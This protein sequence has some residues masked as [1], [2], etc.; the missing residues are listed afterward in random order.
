MMMR[1]F[2]RSKADYTED[3]K[4]KKRSKSYLQGSKQ[5]AT[6]D[7]ADDEHYVAPRTTTSSRRLITAYGVV[8]GVNDCVFHVRP[9]GVQRVATRAHH[10]ATESG[11]SWVKPNNQLA[12]VHIRSFKTLPSQIKS[13][14]RV[15]CYLLYTGRETY[16]VPEIPDGF[17]R[18]HNINSYIS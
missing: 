11:W 13:L 7:G 5:E 3:I 10:C 1:F 12:S 15:R 2:S 8:D 18:R 9:R 17:Q 4:G 6:I 16:H 14:F